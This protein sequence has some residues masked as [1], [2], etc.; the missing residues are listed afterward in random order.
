MPRRLRRPRNGS[1][2]CCDAGLAVFAS[3]EQV[4]HDGS[5]QIFLGH[6]D[7][8]ESSNAPIDSAQLRDEPLAPLCASGA[9]IAALPRRDL[10]SAKLCKAQLAG[11]HRT[12]VEPSHQ[13]PLAISA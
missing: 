7:S 11:G 10:R 5:S 6:F 13:G 2:S 9:S 4:C 1:I 8:A 3:G 12:H